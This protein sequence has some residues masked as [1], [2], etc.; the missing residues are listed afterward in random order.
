MDSKGSVVRIS[1]FALIIIYVLVFVFVAVTLSC[2][3]ERAPEGDAQLPP[4]AVLFDVLHMNYAWGF[5]CTG[6]FIDAAGF[7][8]RYDCGELGDSIRN[9]LYQGREG[10]LLERRFHLKDTIICRLDSA[11]LVRARRLVM[12]AENTPPDSARDS[13]MRDY[14][15]SSYRAFIYDSKNGKRRDVVLRTYGDWERPPS[16]DETGRLAKWLDAATNC[17]DTMKYHSYPWEPAREAPVK[18]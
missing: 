12:K 4:D 1:R 7:V 5:Q 2:G 18:R 6:T 14:G 3:T 11:D 9:R 8:H 15:S 13:G 17:S 10:V 16:S